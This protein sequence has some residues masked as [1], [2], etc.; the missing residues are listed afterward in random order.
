MKFD[1]II[2]NSHFL[3]LWGYEDPKQQ[4]SGRG[5][6]RGYFSNKGVRDITVEKKYQGP[7][8]PY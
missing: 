3:L 4:Y 1:M 2:I 5:C 8:T 6:F 7:K